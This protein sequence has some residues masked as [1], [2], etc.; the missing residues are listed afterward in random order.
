MASKTK[1]WWLPTRGGLQGAAVGF[2]YGRLIIWLL[3][4][5]IISIFLSAVITCA[6]LLAIALWLIHLYRDMKQAERRADRMVALSGQWRRAPW[7]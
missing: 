6:L 7:N 2:G 4:S 1:W 5:H 3:R